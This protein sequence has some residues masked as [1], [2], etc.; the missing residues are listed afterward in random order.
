M[1]TAEED[2]ALG[3]DRSSLREKSFLIRPATTEDVEP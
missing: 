1:S 3:P 2:L